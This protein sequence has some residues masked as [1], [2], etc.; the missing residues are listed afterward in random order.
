MKISQNITPPTMLLIM[1]ESI[2]WVRVYTIVVI[3]TRA[4]LDSSLHPAPPNTQNRSAPG[5]YPDANLAAAP[6]RL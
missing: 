5:C 4:P 3:D 2:Q 6:A 1:L